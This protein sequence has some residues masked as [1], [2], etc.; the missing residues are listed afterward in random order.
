MFETFLNLSDPST[1]EAQLGVVPI[2]TN[3][4]AAVLPAII[5]GMSGFFSLLLRPRELIG[6]C[7]RRPWTTAI[8][9]ASI[10]GA[11]G[12]IY[13]LATAAAAPKVVKAD[14]WNAVALSEI[15]KAQQLGGGASTTSGPA[16]PIGL[17]RNFSRTNYD[18][19]GWPE[20]LSATPIWLGQ[21]K[22]DKDDTRDD[23]TADG[24]ILTCAVVR[25]G[26]VYASGCIDSI[27]GMTGVVFC[28][29]QKTGDEIW[30]IYESAPEKML[31]PMFSSP[32]LT[33]D[34]KHLILG[35]G[36]HEDRNCRLLC[37]E[38]ATGKILWGAE[39]ELHIES[40]PA[41]FT[42]PKYGDVAVVGCGA[43]EGKDRK[44][45]S[46]P[47]HVMAVQ[48]STG[49]ILWKHAVND[50]ES[51][52][53]V[54]ADGTIYIGGGFNG[55]VVVALRPETKEDLGKT[56]REI[57]RAQTPWPATSAVTLIDDVVVVGCGNGD[58]V[59]SD[60]NPR[61]CVLILD[62]KT[63]KEIWRY[64]MKDAVLGEVAA[65][66]DMLIAPCK[67]GEIVALDR[68]QKKLLWT[69]RIS[70]RQ[71]ILAGAAFT[72]ERVFAV[73]SDGYLAVFDAAEN[74]PKRQ[75]EKIRINSEGNPGT[76]NLSVSA[77]TI[78]GGR[79]YVG[80]ETGNIR[81]IGGKVVQN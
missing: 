63:G 52:P 55:S 34:G 47:G 40:S 78:V 25:D 1:G 80:S 10:A 30:R 23:R 67:T 70:G 68:K 77:P 72:G 65:K 71:P 22:R 29:D 7:A 27:T 21:T 62:A 28:L 56:P 2:V 16:A 18:G 69:A 15:A 51:S 37:I 57:W 41:V 53:A 3:V 31:P 19:N 8:T 33:A 64:D 26:R 4:G 81:C 32:V 66:G 43:I 13:L 74:A 45:T 61:G 5:A 49:K 76:Q 6:A 39:S 44:P 9:L 48:V 46:D 12:G 50:P 75:L 14:F 17:G 20:N 11:A 60:P 38:A 73:S 59:N 36:M 42:H 79:I 58:F 24:A 54:G 35:M